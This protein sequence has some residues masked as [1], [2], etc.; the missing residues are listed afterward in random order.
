MHTS[1]VNCHFQFQKMKK[2]DNVRRA[3]RF[4]GTGRTIEISRFTVLKIQNEFFHL[5]PL[6]DG[7][8]RLTVT[9][10]LVADLQKSQTLTIIREELTDKV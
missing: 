6:P 7:T 5:D 4:E 1:G 10:K 8:W 3:F 2:E 9:E